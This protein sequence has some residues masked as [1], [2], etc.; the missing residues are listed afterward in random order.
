MGVIKLYVRG[1]PIL[2]QDLRVWIANDK[3][4]VQQHLDPKR[5]VI[6]EARTIGDNCLSLKSELAAVASREKK[7]QE[8][9]L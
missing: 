7:V 2:A 1:L 8:E 6:S 5:Q 9:L 4:W 3:A